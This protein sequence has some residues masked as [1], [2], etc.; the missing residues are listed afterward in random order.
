MTALAKN[1]LSVVFPDGAGICPVVTNH[2]YSC[3]SYLM[4]EE[5]FDY[6]TVAFHMFRE[7]MDPA[8]Q[9]KIERMFKIKVDNLQED[10]VIGIIGTIGDLNSYRRVIEIFYRSIYYDKNIYPIERVVCNLV[11]EIPL[12][13][14]K[15]TEYELMNNHFTVEYYEKCDTLSESCIKNLFRTLSIENIVKIYYATL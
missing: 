14:N 8:L 11:D 4:N 7:L 12:F 9:K 10:K 1:A 6:Y 2:R 3:C 15:I 13:N 5:T